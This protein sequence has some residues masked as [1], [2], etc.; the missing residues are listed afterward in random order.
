M[1]TAAVLY[2]L[3]SH[4][5]VKRDTVDLLLPAAVA[6]DWFVVMVLIVWLTWR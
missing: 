5:A 2:Y 4:P 6:T 1:I 3:F